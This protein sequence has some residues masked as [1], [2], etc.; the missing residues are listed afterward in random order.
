MGCGASDA[1]VHRTPESGIR[2]P[3]P[4]TIADYPLLLDVQSDL[5]AELGTHV[6]GPLC[7]AAAMTD[8]LLKTLTPVFEVEGEHYVMLTP[9]L[10]RIPER[11]LGTSVAGLDLLITGI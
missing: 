8:R 9:Q 1:S 6:V 2:N 5:I 11:R 10:V 7:P 4:D 3:N